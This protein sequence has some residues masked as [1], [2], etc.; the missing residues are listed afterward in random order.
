MLT[1]DLA[2]IQSNWL[3]LCAVGVN[4]TVAG[5]IKANAY[6]LGAAQVGNALYGVGCRE[7]FFAS[8]NEALAARTFLPTDT[9]I[10]V[11]GGIGAGNEKLLIESKL[12]PVLC[13]TAAIRGWVKANIDLGARASS[14]I[15]IN[16]GMTR[17]G[18]DLKEFEA[19]CNNVDLV[20]VTNPSLVMSHLACADERHHPLNI[21]QRERFLSCTRL[22]SPL[23][24]GLRFSLANSAGIFL[25]REWHFDLLRPG[26]A[27]YG[28]NPSPD[29]PNPMLPV[30]RL[31]LPIVQVRRLDAPSAIGYGSSV[32]LPAGARIA[33][34]AGGYADGLHRTLGLQPEGILN[35]EL[36]RAVG[37]IS[38]D[39]TMFD[40]TGI[41]L[42]D[43]QLIGCE[44]EVINS[45]LSLDYLSK[46]NNS[47]GYEVLTSLGG[48]YQRRYLTGANDDR[49]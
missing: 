33:V 15:K 3:K 23:V 28:I 10:Y 27:L 46:K 14:A 12:T 26:A 38:M 37:R 43:D 13:S 8:I 34:V 4:A 21:Q 19:F 1:I 31:T 41:D 30:V 9:I 20:R 2:A 44:I 18:L 48:R 25:G 35:G 47:L 24:S 40:I 17:F 16:T 45:S 5:V 22:I 39:S 42:P 7:F 6:G 32:A 29:T 36:I 49:K 11:L